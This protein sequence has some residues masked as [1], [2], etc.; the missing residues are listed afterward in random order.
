MGGLHG[1][2]LRDQVR[3]VKDPGKPSSEALFLSAG[4]RRPWLAAD[5]ASI[6][7]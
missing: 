6:L 4:Q 5:S 2:G 3:A 7:T 1:E